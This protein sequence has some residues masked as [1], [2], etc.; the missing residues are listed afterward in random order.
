MSVPPPYA[1]TNLQL[2]AQLVSLGFPDEGLRLARAAHDC[3]ASLFSGQ[4]RFSGKPFL[5]HLVGAAS[6]VA[7]HGGDA[8][9]VAAALLHA[10]YDQG[11]FGTGMRG[12]SP[13]KRR[14]LRAAIGDDAESL[15]ARYDAF[16]F[17]GGATFQEGARDVLFLRAANEL[18]D[19]LD[20]GALFAGPARLRIAAR[21]IRRAAEAASWL[22]L[23]GLEGEI[24]S[25]L[26]TL[27]SSSLP[28]PLRSDR[29]GTYLLR[30]RSF[31][32]RLVS[33]LGRRIDR[34]RDRGR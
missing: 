15:V 33:A 3:A 16:D 22:G 18:E 8:R 1:Q 30:P 31:R 13:R 27:E 5:A 29:E 34:L 6:I 26:A 9:A 12:A 17:Q 2:Y 20:L 19:A 24:R 14:E 32:R 4:H 11:D 7:A 25:A 21:S 10:A 23:P 28:A